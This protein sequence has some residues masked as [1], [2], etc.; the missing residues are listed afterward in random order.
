[1]V[2]YKLLEKQREFME[3]SHS[4]ALDVAMYQGGFGS[5]KT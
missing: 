5:G 1:M 3:I 4:N 2:N